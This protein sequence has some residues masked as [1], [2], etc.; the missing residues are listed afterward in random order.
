[1]T[2]IE[3]SE[4]LLEKVQR[5]KRERASAIL[6]N[7]REVYNEASGLRTKLAEKRKLQELAD[8]EE[9]KEGG[10]LNDDA[11]I[12]KEKSKLSDISALEYTAEEDDKWQIKQ[13]NLKRH[14]E[15]IDTDNGE[16]QN[17]KQL[18]AN[19]YSKNIRELE[20]ENKRKTIEEYEK[21][22]KEYESMKA[23][24]LSDAEIRSALTSN[25]KLKEYID[26]VNKWEQKVYNKRQK[27]SDEGK[28]GAIHEKNRLFN[29][30]LERHN[31]QMQDT[32]SNPN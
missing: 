18:A 17:Y 25:E 4:N 13:G 10:S 15:S 26:K 21:E 8:R 32:K 11:P 3:K 12:V 29:S 1:M 22:K 27:I 28:E 30:K 2:S 9:E 16:L 5:L 14:F 20:E 7:R 23:Q 19:T 31:K 24:G 6:D